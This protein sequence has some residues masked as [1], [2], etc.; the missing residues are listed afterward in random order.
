MDDI[1]WAFQGS[2]GLAKAAK[3]GESYCSVWRPSNR[4]FPYYQCSHDA[5]MEGVEHGDGGGVWLTQET[6]LMCSWLLKAKP[7]GS[8]RSFLFVCMTSQ[9]ARESCEGPACFSWTRSLCQEQRW[10]L[11]QQYAIQPSQALTWSNFKGRRKPSKA[12]SKESIRSGRGSIKESQRLRR[13]S[14]T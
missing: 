9:F 4:P 1:D 8:T 7:H 11:K 14:I 3:F 2:G 6:T 13:M 10:M 5:L 12:S